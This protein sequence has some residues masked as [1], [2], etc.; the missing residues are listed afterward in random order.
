MLQFR[1][2]IQVFQ[3]IS[4][5]FRFSKDCT[6]ILKKAKEDCVLF[7]KKFGSIFLFKKKMKNL[8]NIWVYV[9]E[10]F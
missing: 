1:I 7:Y 3:E 2:G 5:I 9:T 10:L 8:S 4:P 6:L